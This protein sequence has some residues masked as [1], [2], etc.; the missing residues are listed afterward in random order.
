[1]IRI[2]EINFASILIQIELTEDVIHL[3]SGGFVKIVKLS[4]NIHGSG[5]HNAVFIKV[6][7][8]CAALRIV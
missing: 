6:V 8:I 1:M 2:E 4:V 7:I 3:T 5:L